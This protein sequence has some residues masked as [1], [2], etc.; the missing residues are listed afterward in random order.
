MSETPEA[1]ADLQA[2]G[3]A[4]WAAV[5]AAYEL[6]PVE[7][8]QLAEACA[9]ADVVAALS[10]AVSEHGVVDADGR[11]SLAVTELRQSRLLA[12]KMLLGLRLPDES[13]SSRPQH[14]VGARAAGGAR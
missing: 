5:A 13:D 14:R 4:L 11:P 12:S 3:T 7:L 8:L 2:A 6:D 10:A 9:A 1:P